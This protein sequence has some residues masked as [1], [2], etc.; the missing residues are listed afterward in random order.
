YTG[1]VH[2][3]AGGSTR[4]HACGAVLIARDWYTLEEWQLTDEGCCRACGTRC[5]GIFDG[6]PGTWGAKRRPVLLSV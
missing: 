5:P 1:N 4:C 2:D 3:V 6:P